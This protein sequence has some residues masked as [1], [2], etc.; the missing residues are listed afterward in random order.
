MIIFGAVMGC[1]DAALT[2]AAAAEND[3]FA[4]SMELRKKVRESRK[5]FAMGS[6][7]DHVA[8]VNAYNTI[9]AAPPAERERLCHERYLNY[10]K[11]SNISKYKRQY[12][13][14]LGAAWVGDASPDG[15]RHARGDL[16]ID[17]SAASAYS[18]DTALIKAVVAAGLF[19]NVAMINSQAVV[20]TSKRPGDDSAL[21]TLRSKMFN[22]IDVGKNSVVREKKAP[23]VKANGDE[24]ALARDAGLQRRSRSPWYMYD[25]MMS[26]AGLGR[27]LNSVSQTGLWAIVLLGCSAEHI[28]HRPHLGLATVDGWLLFRCGE[29]SM[30][31]VVQ[32]KRLLDHAILTKFQRPDDA[33]NS[34]RLGHIVALVRELITDG[35]RHHSPGVGSEA[36]PSSNT[37]GV[38]V[39]PLEPLSP[40][41]TVGT[42]RWV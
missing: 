11:I 39:S 3:P 22:S 13:D 31:R 9:A 26:V 38:V 30:R 20:A 6:S 4:G 18:C 19:P 37:D 15:G 25:H 28:A 23:R 2:L 12:Y 5:Q 24:A 1:L 36:T 17:R 34:A 27:F 32:L 14:I 35:A 10:V 41:R 33:A 8:C 40:S 21:T 29:A 7:S 42:S 16:F